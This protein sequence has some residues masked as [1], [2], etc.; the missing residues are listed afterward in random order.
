MTK[1][2]ANRVGRRLKHKPKGG[3]PAGSFRPLLT[4]PQRF[5]VA[6]WLL[7]EPLYGPHVAAHLAIVA[8]EET[9]PMSLAPWKTCCW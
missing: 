3:R 6:A 2:S 5:S 4:D 9:T 7:L 1:S 8:I